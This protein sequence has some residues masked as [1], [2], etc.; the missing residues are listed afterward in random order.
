[1]AAH[2]FGRVT[3]TNGAPC[4]HTPAPGWV[5]VRAAR[6]VP[7]GQMVESRGTRT[8]GGDK[9]GSFAGPRSYR[10]R[11]RATRISSAGPSGPS[12]AYHRPHLRP[13]SAAAHG[14][15]RRLGYN[16]ETP[17]SQNHNGPGDSGWPVL[18]LSTRAVHF[19]SHTE[20]CDA[21][22]EQHKQQRNK[23]VRAL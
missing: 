5:K 13:E 14:Q 10:D 23:H 11:R 3:K 2:G 7:R 8:A 1:M 18:M 6:A 19:S 16:G 21:V 9:T 20:R 22:S 12:P 4:S 15:S 17:A